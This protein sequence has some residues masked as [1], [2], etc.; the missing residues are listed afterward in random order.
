MLLTA[1]QTSAEFQR[2]AYDGM[3][4]AFRDEHSLSEEHPDVIRIFQLTLSEQLSAA[5]FAIIFWSRSGVV[6]HLRDQLAE[7][8]GRPADEVFAEA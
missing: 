8:S 1:L 4:T 5:F 7:F 2:L 6:P 3:A